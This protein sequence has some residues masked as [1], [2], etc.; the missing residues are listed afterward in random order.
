MIN[1]NLPKDFK[2]ISIKLASPNAIRN[3]AE[4]LLP[5]GTVVGE[6]TKSETI[7]YRTFKPEPDGLF[8]EKIF[9]PVKN[10]EC[11]CGKTKH[12]R[13]YQDDDEDQLPP[14][15]APVYCPYCHVEITEST[16]RRYR[17]GYI[18]LAAPAVHIWYLK[19]IPS[20]LAILLESR[21]KDLESIIY[22]TNFSGE[23]E[24]ESMTAS[25][26]GKWNPYC[27]FAFLKYTVESE[28]T[29]YVFIRDE[30][31]SWTSKYRCFEDTTETFGAH[32]ISQKLEELDIDKTIKTRFLEY[33]K[34]PKT[35]KH[36]ED[37]KEAEKI[38][39]KKK[40]VS[41]H[42]NLLLCFLKSRIDPRWMVID[43]LPVLPPELRP[44]VQLGNGRFATS[45]LNDLYRRVINR[46][47]RLTRFFEIPAPTLIIRNEKRLLQEG[48]D[49][50]IDNGR[51]GPAVLGSN[52]RPLKSLADSLGGKQGRFRQNLLGKRVDYSGRSVIVVGPSLQL[53]QCGLPKEMALELFRPF[54]IRRLLHYRI[55]QTMRGAKERIEAGG[56][57]IDY[58][59][60]LVIKS[61][62]ILLNRA[63]TLH[64]L[65]FQAFQ[66]I[67]IQ[68]RAIQLHPLVCPAFN[69]DFD[70]DQM[71][72][73]IPLS[74]EAQLEARLLMLATNNWLSPSNGEPVLLPS[75][76]MVLGCY[77]LTIE[78]ASLSLLGKEKNYLTDYNQAHL[79]FQTNKEIHEHVWF[80]CSRSQLQSYLPKEEPLEIR[81][82]QHK[83]HVLYTRAQMKKT[84][85]LPPQNQIDLPFYDEI[86]IR[87]TIGR[88]LF[89]QLVEQALDVDTSFTSLKQSSYQQKR[90]PNPSSDF[91]SPIEVDKIFISTKNV[92]LVQNLMELQNSQ[93]KQLIPSETNEKLSR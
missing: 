39:K 10:W 54:L 50:L 15:E 14:E 77:F 23:K 36:W 62:S 46:N 13:P 37:T 57:L 18:K 20:Y 48:V 55:A 60:K 45:D 44:M 11:Y 59:L 72:V 82:S 47:N 80:K 6:V 89:N 90:S 69:A 66:P 30:L 79:L 68:G 52:S 9:G 70:G 78:D 71:A 34:F 38:N 5:D 31:I 21:P 81:V 42:L 73:H 53:H 84:Q 16:V 63:P 25:P 51:R 56:E 28:N 2:C 40:Q 64:R 67:I 27:W 8:C 22:F 85:K 35:T 65:G 87:T 24:E 86:Y 41:R 74:I 91:Y 3:W 93:R 1:T 19:S 43:F 75:Q 4:R 61:H 33:S 58:L 26:K 76:D 83:V 49:A 17:M 12:T 32:V 88:L 7:N 29:W 92:S